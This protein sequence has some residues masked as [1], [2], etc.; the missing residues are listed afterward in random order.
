MKI[1]GQEVKHLIIPIYLVFLLISLGLKGYSSNNYWSLGI[2]SSIKP[3]IERGIVK[4]VYVLQANKDKEYIKHI[5]LILFSTSTAFIILYLIVL[6]SLSD[7]KEGIEFNS[8]N[9]NNSNKGKRNELPQDP[10]QKNVHEIKTFLLAYPIIILVCNNLSFTSIQPIIYLYIHLLKTIGYYISYGEVGKS[11]EK[12]LALEQNSYI[13]QAI[14][15]IKDKINLICIEVNRFKEERESRTDKGNK[16]VLILND[17]NKIITL[18][19]EPKE[20]INNLIRISS[21]G[22]NGY[23][24]KLLL[25]FNNQEDCVQ[26][27]ERMGGTELGIIEFKSGN[28]SQIILKTQGKDDKT[29]LFPTKDSI[30]KHLN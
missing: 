3:Y 9:S 19:E 16:E 1:L 4:E 25:I 2:P 22:L 24:M 14:G 30:Q 21:M 10:Q 7:S 27:I 28:K 26:S 29:L 17:V 12:T 20:L 5:S 18:S 11:G 6:I 13:G 23:E 15:K 8:S